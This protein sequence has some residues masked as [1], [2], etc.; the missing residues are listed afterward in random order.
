MNPVRSMPET[1]PLLTEARVREVFR[2]YHRLTSFGVLGVVAMVI[3]SAWTAATSP[4]GRA[5]AVAQTLSSDRV[6]RLIAQGSEKQRAEAIAMLIAFLGADEARAQATALSARA[7]AEGKSLLDRPWKYTE[8]DYS[9]LHCAVVPDAAQHP[10]QPQEVDAV[11]GALD[12]IRT[13]DRYLARRF[14]NAQK[15]GEVMRADPQSRV[16]LA[17]S[18]IRGVEARKWLSRAK[19]S[20]VAGNRFG[21]SENGLEFVQGLYAAGAAKVVVPGE[22][23]ERD[24]G[25]GYDHAES[26]RVYLP[27]DSDARGRVLEIVNREA[28][29]EGLDGVADTGQ[30]HVILWWD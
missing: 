24:D 13:L 6:E 29:R 27:N 28:R 25:S 10:I 30:N 19:P 2:E 20:I 4:G 22:S 26:L 7:A 16:R 23:I 11:C 14:L 5:A 21:T 17:G 9:L 12:E 15:I 1:S 8:W 18:R 3:R